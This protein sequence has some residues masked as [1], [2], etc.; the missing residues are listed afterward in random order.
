M[1]TFTLDTSGAVLIRVPDIPGIHGRQFHS[2][3]WSDLSPF[4]Q[5]YVEG[6]FADFIAT[7]LVKIGVPPGFSD[8]SPEALALIRRDCEAFSRDFTGK[9]RMAEAGRQFWTD[10]QRGLLRT[11]PPLAPY[12]SDDGKVHLREGA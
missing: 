9:G 7:K 2:I 6:L 10:R 3:K 5:G 4:E 12:L 8:L 11:Y 1:N